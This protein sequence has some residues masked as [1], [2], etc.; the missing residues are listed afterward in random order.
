MAQAITINCIPTSRQILLLC[1][2]AHLNTCQPLTF[3]S[4]S[5]LNDATILKLLVSG[6]DSGNQCVLT[7]FLLYPRPGITSRLLGP[8][9]SSFIELVMSGMCKWV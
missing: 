9:W 8:L 4:K 6:T 7:V 2:D 3:H 5:H 1:F